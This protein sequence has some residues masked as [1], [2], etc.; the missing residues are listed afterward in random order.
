MRAYQYP[1]LSL[2]TKNKV[3]NSSTRLAESIARNAMNAKA[4]QTKAGGADTCTT[5]L[6]SP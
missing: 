4:V 3:A 5:R 2:R 6:Y 1:R